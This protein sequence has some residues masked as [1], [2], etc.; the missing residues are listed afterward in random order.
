MGEKINSYFLFCCK[1]LKLFYVYG[2]Y[3]TWI[4]QV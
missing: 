3:E 4:I 2:I 1:L